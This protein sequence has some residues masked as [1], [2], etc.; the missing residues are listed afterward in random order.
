MKIWFLEIAQE[1]GN[2]A[3]KSWRSRY[4]AYIPAAQRVRMPNGEDKANA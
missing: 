2:A 1:A 3:G 4:G